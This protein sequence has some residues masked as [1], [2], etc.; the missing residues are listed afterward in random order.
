MRVDLHN[1]DE[2][3]SVKW[4]LYTSAKSIDQVRNVLPFFQFLAYQRAV[5]PHDSFVKTESKVIE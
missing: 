3:N 1:I 5:L 2:S 4:A